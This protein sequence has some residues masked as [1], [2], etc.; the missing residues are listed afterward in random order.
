MLT[1]RGWQETDITIYAAHPLSRAREYLSELRR[2]VSPIENVTKGLTFYA[3]GLARLATRGVDA[4][5]ITTAEGWLA[6]AIPYYEAYIDALNGQPND[7]KQRIFRILEQAPELVGLVFE[8]QN[9]RY[10]RLRQKIGNP[11]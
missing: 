9:D 3:L 6:N 11:S 1:S 8:S 7:K 2:G 5:K 4:N 10:A